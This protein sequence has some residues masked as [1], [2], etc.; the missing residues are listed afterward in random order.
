M[1]F[2]SHGPTLKHRTGSRA[3]SQKAQNRDEQ[4]TREEENRGN[5]ERVDMGCGGWNRMGKEQES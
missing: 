1:N 3:S 2:S 5:R 4:G